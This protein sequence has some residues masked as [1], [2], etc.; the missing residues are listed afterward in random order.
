MQN[1]YYLNV[2]DKILK[3]LVEEND[4]KSPYDLELEIDVVHK[5]QKIKL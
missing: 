5:T 4:G 1:P 3:S 2:K